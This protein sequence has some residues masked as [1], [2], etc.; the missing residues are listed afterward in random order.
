MRLGL[1]LAK[2]KQD[3]KGQFAF[4]A[5]F[6][7]CAAYQL[8]FA[9]RACCSAGVSAALYASV[10]SKN[11]ARGA[12]AGSSAGTS[13][14]D[15][16]KAPPLLLQFAQQGAVIRI[17]CQGARQGLSL[18]AAGKMRPSAAMPPTTATAATT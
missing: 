1:G 18:A 17:R 6:L 4:F 11:S 3:C 13:S 8:D 10:F 7:R 14:R 16:H 15:A 9:A 2:I 5:I 12:L